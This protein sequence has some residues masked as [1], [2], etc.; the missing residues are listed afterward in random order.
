V[1]FWGIGSRLG[2]PYADGLRCREGLI[3]KNKY[4]E[5]IEMFYSMRVV[6]VAGMLLVSVGCKKAETPVQTQ[7]GGCGY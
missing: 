2:C 4:Y 5:V 3:A 1:V 7:P 6:V